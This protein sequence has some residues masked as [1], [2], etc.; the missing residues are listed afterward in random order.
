MAEADVAANNWVSD[1][2]A[3][4]VLG[5]AVGYWFGHRAE[6]SGKASDSMLMLMAHGVAMTMALE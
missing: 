4:I 1:T 6:V 5:Y 2:A 3:G